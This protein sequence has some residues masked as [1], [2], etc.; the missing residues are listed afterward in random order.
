MLRIDCETCGQELTSAL[1]WRSAASAVAVG[2][3]L[4]LLGV[5]GFEALGRLSTITP[6]VRLILFYG[7][8]GGVFGYSA[9]RV[10]KSMEYRPWS[11]KL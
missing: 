1:T 10:L 8:L 6:A 2:L 3:S 7:Y 4:I 11:P 5:A 9:Q